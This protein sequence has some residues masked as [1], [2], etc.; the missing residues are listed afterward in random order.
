VAG[1]GAVAGGTSHAGRH[2]GCLDVHD[3]VRRVW[4]VGRRPY[5]ARLRHDAGR[6]AVQ[7]IVSRHVR[8][9]VVLEVCDVVFVQRRHTR[10]T[11]D[12]HI[13]TWQSG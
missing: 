7:V 4:P 10:N 13:C 2:V 1:D 8:H 3:G 5:L 11:H 12:H 6:A 9:D